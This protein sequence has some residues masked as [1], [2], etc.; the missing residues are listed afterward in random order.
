[1]VEQGP[2]ATPGVLGSPVAGKL[3]SSQFKS[4]PG[5]WSSQMLRANTI[6]RAI[7]VPNCCSPPLVVNVSASWKTPFCVA[8]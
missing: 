8:Q 5:I 2:R 1:M 6:P 7:A 3:L 4:L